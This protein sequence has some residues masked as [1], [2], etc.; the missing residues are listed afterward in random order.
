MLVDHPCGSISLSF[1]YRRNENFSLS[2]NE[3][4]YYKSIFRMSTSVKVTHDIKIFEFVTHNFGFS[5]FLFFWGQ[6]PSCCFNALQYA[7]NLIPVYRLSKA[8]VPLVKSPQ[9]TAVGGFGLHQ[10]KGS[11][12]P[13]A[14]A[15]R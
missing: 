13:S 10:T 12:I 8:S 4:C 14:N 3:I 2:P 9:T 5:L 7:N 11:F 15:K 1:F 6:F